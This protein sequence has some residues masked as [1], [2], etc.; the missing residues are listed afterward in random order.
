MEYQITLEEMRILRLR[1]ANYEERRM[2]EYAC[3]NEELDLWNTTRL[4]ELNRE[5]E[6]RRRME[7]LSHAKN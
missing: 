7:K 1:E 4:A 6:C 3:Y 5:D 2:Q